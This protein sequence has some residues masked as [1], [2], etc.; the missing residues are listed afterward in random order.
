MRGQKWFVRALYSTR[1]SGGGWVKINTT[2][3]L[4][5]TS[6]T[7]D[8]NNA[9]RVAIA[10][11]GGTAAPDIR[12]WRHALGIGL[13]KRSVTVNATDAPWMQTKYP[14]RGIYFI[15]DGKILFDPR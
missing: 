10:A 8:P 1:T 15:T 4:M 14:P 6:I 7:V 5:F 3:H 12:R 11:G 2:I 13:A 9:S